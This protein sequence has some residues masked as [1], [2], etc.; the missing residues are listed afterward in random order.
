MAP[1]IALKTLIPMVVLLKYVILE[2]SYIVF[3]DSHI[4]WLANNSKELNLLLLLEFFI[5]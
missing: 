4:I 3:I 1:F 2:M 5:L